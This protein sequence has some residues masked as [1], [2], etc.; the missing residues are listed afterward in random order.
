MEKQ[1]HCGIPSEAFKYESEEISEFPLKLR[2]QIWE[3]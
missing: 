1:L 2:N 3:A